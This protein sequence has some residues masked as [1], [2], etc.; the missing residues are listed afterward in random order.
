MDPGSRD[1]DATTQTLVK[2]ARAELLT[3]GQAEFAMEGVARR[4]FY[5]IGAVYNR[6]PDRESLL[7]DLAAEVIIREGRGGH[8]WDVAG[9][10]YIDYLLGSG[11][12]YIGHNHPK[13]T[14]A[15]LAQVPKGTTFFTNNEH[16][17]RLAA[18]GDGG[19]RL[20][21]VGIDV[22]HRRAVE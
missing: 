10:E 7:S 17:I 14:E 15:V 20:A 16:G 11:P 4:G 3:V 9:R 6:W 22:R 5:S 8:V 18:A 13:V 21:G 1:R 12:M 2:A 19:P